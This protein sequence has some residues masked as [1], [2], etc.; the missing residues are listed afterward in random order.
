MIFTNRAEAGKR[1]AGLLLPLRNKT[2]IILGLPRGG[3]P[4]ALE[5]ARELHCPLDLIIVRKLGVPWQ[6]ELAFG[7]V[8]EGG[9]LI[10]NHL[11]IT[12]LGI[13]KVDQERII[14]QERKVISERQRQYRGGRAALDLTD[15]CAVIVDDGIATGATVEVACMEARKRGASEV[16]VACPVASRQAVEHL[17]T[18][19][20]RCSVVHIPKEFDA[21]GLWY[22]DFTPVSDEEVVAVMN[23]GSSGG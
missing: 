7:A 16:V 2:P 17:S 11:I 21:V 19:A 23:R 12:E 15:R 5:V 13:S 22:Q 18:I 8:G 20:D 14:G 6:P 9:E 10:L 1:L 4:V 3:V